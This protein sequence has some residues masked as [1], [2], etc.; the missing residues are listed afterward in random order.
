MYGI[1]S[2]IISQQQ[3]NNYAGTG[4]KYFDWVK[5]G[6]ISENKSQWNKLIATGTS[7]RRLKERVIAIIAH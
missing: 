2:F 3:L 1:C 4:K 5:P 7:Q 6:L